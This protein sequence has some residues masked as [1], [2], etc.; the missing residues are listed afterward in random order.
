MTVVVIQIYFSC[1]TDALIQQTIRRE[2]SEC[3]VL[4]IAHRLHT[5]MDSDRIIVLDAGRLVEYD[6]PYKLLQ[7]ANGHFSSMVKTTG[8]I[9]EK[10]L[11]NIAYAPYTTKL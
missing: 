2:F 1:S 7:L 4:T 3:T 6:E 9:T 8:K 11:R 5:I 10:S